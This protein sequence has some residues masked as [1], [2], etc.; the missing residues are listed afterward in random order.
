MIVAYF[1]Q[2]TLLQNKHCR[3]S[4]SGRRTTIRNSCVLFHLLEAELESRQVD[5]R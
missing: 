1:S 4:T 5:P 2:T 3:I